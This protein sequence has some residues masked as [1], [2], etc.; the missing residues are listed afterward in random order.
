M[1]MENDF[2]GQNQDIDDDEQKEED[3]QK[4]DDVFSNV[5]QSELD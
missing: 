3:E 4:Q 2:D 5:D 1:E